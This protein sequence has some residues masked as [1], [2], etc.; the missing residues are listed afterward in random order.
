MDVSLRRVFGNAG[1]FLGS[2]TVVGLLSLFYIGL[3]ARTLG[4]SGFGAFALV[5]GLGQAIAGFVT[6]QTW[7]IVVRYGMP[8]FQAGEHDRLDDL[9]LLC[10]LLDAA[11]ALA[12]ALLAT[13]AI[14]ILAPWFGWTP[15]VMWQA[16]LFCAAM[17]LSLRSTPI[18]MLRLHDRFAAAAASDSVTPIVRLIGAG[19]AAICAPGVAGF[20]I[21]WA[22]AEIATAIACWW[23][24]LKHHP[25][26]LRSGAMRRVLAR[27]AGILRFA[28][29]TNAGSTLSLSVRQLVL[30][31][32]GSI[33][34]AAAAGA[35]RIAAQ[36]SQAIAK[37]TLAF[38]RAVFPELVRAGAGAVPDI[39]RLTARMTMIAMIA[40]CVAF[41]LVL[42]LGRQMLV[43]LSGQDIPSAYVP[44]LLLTSAAALELGGVSLEPALTAMGR[45]G[46]ALILRALAA[47]LQIGLLIALLP[48]VGLLSAGWAA[49]A[50]SGFALLLTGLA[51]RRLFLTGDKRRLGEPA[52]MLPI[53]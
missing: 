15:A 7:Q 38:S 49:L 4:L 26:G 3:A 17:L 32:V 42:L 29:L 23:F 39:R 31:I 9:I 22:C 52:Q 25:L 41:V 34:G 8:H 13:I 43:L 20:L 10:A 44:M 12:G 1:W 11:S 45:L 2:R 18:G 5:V 40:G 27:E 30:L 35:F 19:V 36:L 53:N 46:L 37:L 50:S 6:F 33:G 48:Y 24:A 47:A 28:W 16:G 21:A 51:V 14:L